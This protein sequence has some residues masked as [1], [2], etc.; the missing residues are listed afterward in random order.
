MAACSSTL[1]TAE[2]WS[3]I[4]LSLIAAISRDHQLRQC[5]G[6][7]IEEAS[8]SA[9]RQATWLTELCKTQILEA[10][11]FNFCK[12]ASQMTNLTKKLKWTFTR[13]WTSI[14]QLPRLF[15]FWTEL[16]SISQWRRRVRLI[17]T[18]MLTFGK[19]ILRTSMIFKLKQSCKSQIVDQTR[20]E[21]KVEGAKIKRD[22]KAKE[23]WTL[24][25]KR[26]TKMILTTS[27][28]LNRVKMEMT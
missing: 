20:R 22:K 25:Q 6:P 19:S 8:Q 2:F 26:T 21:K 3:I 17:F 24:V 5:S 28:S 13:S 18:S 1:A 11:L 16:S 14:S 23:T 9:D 27:L 10:I 7:R 12:S 15:S 4:W